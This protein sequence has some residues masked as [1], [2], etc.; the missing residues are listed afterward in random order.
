MKYL[1][2]RILQSFFLLFGVSL[3]SFAFVELA[4]GNFFD[5]IRL[6]PQIS[7][8]TLA[9]LRMQYGMEQPLPVRYFRW[10]SSAARANSGSRSPIT[11]LWPLSFGRERATRC[12]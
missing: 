8:E 1:G 5:E 4:P 7:S 10:L 11:L 3:L 12:C 9:N 2:H 6:N